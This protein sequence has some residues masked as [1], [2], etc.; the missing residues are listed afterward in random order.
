MTAT[1][2]FY[3]Q[4][5]RWAS[6]WLLA[7]GLFAAGKASVLLSAR[8]MPHGWR[9]P[10]F[11]FLWPGMD[12]KPWAVADVRRAASSLTIRAAA[13]KILFGAVMLWGMAR[14]F[15]NPLAAGWCGMI[16]LIFVLHLGLFDAL[17]IFWKHLGIPVAPI[18]DNPIAATSLA[19][20]WG[21][22]WNLA[23][24]DLT[25][26]IVFRP[27]AHRLGLKAA[28]WVSFGVSGL[29]H[30]LVISVPAGAGFG[31]PTAYFILQAVGILLERGLFPKGGGF[32]EA[33]LE[34]VLH[35]RVYGTACLFPLSP[36][37]R[38]ARDGS[39]LPRHWSLAMKMIFTLQNAL[40][41]AGLGHFAILSASALVPRV[42]DWETVLK[43][44]PPFLRTLFW[45]ARLFVQLFVFDA[46]PYLTN[47]WLKIGDHLLTLTFV[48]FVSVYAF[49]TFKH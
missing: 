5:P 2:D 47:V 43:P 38:G 32:G 36:A 1:N 33:H 28:L 31:L 27:A 15:E 44:L 19:E 29:A 3:D 21:R 12:V 4:L 6:M 10:A 39:L 17:A 49:A 22:R 30:E 40:L 7:G 25:H 20:F 46:W 48:V 23:F 11:S 9:L 45:G 16:G 26:P 41:L 24:R 37:I 14:Y 8:Q 34:V 42:L 35:A 13:V 18:M